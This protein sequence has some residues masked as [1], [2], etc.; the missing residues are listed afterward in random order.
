MTEQEEKRLLRLTEMTRRLGWGVTTRRFSA[1]A[2]GLAV[3]MRRDASSVEP[4]PGLHVYSKS[5]A[6]SAMHRMGMRVREATT[7]RTVPLQLVV[8]EGTRWFQ[9]LTQLQGVDPSLVFNMD[10]WFCLLQENHSWTW[11]R[12]RKGEAQQVSIARDK[13]GCTSS[14]LSSMDG[15][16]HLVQLIW[17]G[18]TNSV[19]ARVRADEEDARILQQHRKGSHFQNAETFTVWMR[20]FVEL[21]TPIRQGVID[22]MRSA[23][24]NTDVPATERTPTDTI[25]SK[26]DAATQTDFTAFLP[27]ALLSELQNLVGDA[28]PISAD[29]SHL[30]GRA[31]PVPDAP[32][33]PASDPAPP[34]A[35]DALTNADDPRTCVYLLLDAATQHV[36]VDYT[37]PSWVK[38]LKIPSSLTHVFQPADQLVIPTLKTKCNAGYVAWIAQQVKDYPDAIA[39]QI[40]AGKIAPPST[41]ENGGV[42]AWGKTP[43]KRYLKYR[44]LSAAMNLVSESAITR[45]WAMAGVFRSMGLRQPQGSNGKA[46]DIIF[47]D[48]SKLFEEDQE[49]D[50]LLQETVEVERASATAAQNVETRDTAADEIA[51]EIPP[52][53]VPFV[54]PPSALEPIQPSQASSELASFS[55]VPPARPKPA[56]KP[57][58]PKRGPGRPPAKSKP[59][60]KGQ[61]RLPFLP[62]KKE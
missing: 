12:V 39:A 36:C 57:A 18:E 10:E 56:A 38:I 20:K 54:P 48:Y 35:A 51:S 14:V 61:M 44:C 41:T 27:E 16:L 33:A 52:A 28:K 62:V 31:E 17:A 1:L 24:A 55:Q 42:A 4:I 34:A 11:T 37:A 32:T 13:L 23:T 59:P 30:L 45:S 2:R 19:H 26:A 40:V 47:D 9:E 25:A 50:K 53:S 21:A 60:P 6:N 7:D 3:K 8:E 15:K 22:A 46:V 5:W 49:L 43:Y 58:G 29:L